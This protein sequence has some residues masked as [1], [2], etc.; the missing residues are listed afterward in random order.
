MYLRVAEADPRDGG[1]VCDGVGAVD[2]PRQLAN[3][4]SPA[5]QRGRPTAR[6]RRG[7]GRR[8]I[9]PTR[10][11]P[12]SRRR[13]PRAAAPC[14]KQAGVDLDREREGDALGIAVERG[15]ARLRRA[16][17]E[18][19]TAPSTS[20]SRGPWE[21]DA[22]DRRRRPP[23]ASHKAA[24]ALVEAGIAHPVA[25]GFGAPALR[26]APHPS[27][28]PSRGAS[29]PHADGTAPVPRAGPRDRVSLPVATAAATRAGVGRQLDTRRRQEGANKRAGAAATWSSRR[30]APGQ[31]AVVEVGREL[32]HGRGGEEA[33]G[34]AKMRVGSSTAALSSARA[35]QVDAARPASAN[36]RG[37]RS[38][39]IAKS[40]SQA[41]DRRRARVAPARRR[42]RRCG[43][44]EAPQRAARPPAQPMTSMAERPDRTGRRATRSSSRRPRHHVPPRKSI[45]GR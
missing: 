16:K 11:P 21:T 8:P 3:C 17:T 33:V 15:A 39:C 44:H 18:L 36:T 10:S 29:R 1:A 14:A 32:A 34:D 4:A 19:I 28:T 6:G 20:A 41:Q 38:G 24:A 43:T 9:Q 40:R 25:G 22:D 2:Q 30:R 7:A 31:R 23:R 42:R 45:D 27:R 13:A 35:L 37:A 12:C 5:R 26:A